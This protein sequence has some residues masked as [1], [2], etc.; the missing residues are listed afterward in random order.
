[1]TAEVAVNGLE[2]EVRIDTGSPV[3]I[4]SLPFIMKV[5]LQE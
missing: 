3:T 4:G 1:M 5:F 2:T